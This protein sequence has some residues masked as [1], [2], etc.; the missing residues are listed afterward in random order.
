M[1]TTN[2]S[3]K[4]M[5]VNL[6]DILMKHEYHWGYRDSILDE[7]LSLINNN[8]K[9]FTKITKSN[10]NSFNLR[11]YGGGKEIKIG[12]KI[13]FGFVI[14]YANINGIIPTKVDL[15]PPPLTMIEFVLPKNEM[16]IY[17]LYKK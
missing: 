12:D 2:Y 9:P 16:M 1:E 4:E 10:I 3:L 5:K 6:R 8:N 14:S 11:Y 7:I 17:Q 15:I 13:I